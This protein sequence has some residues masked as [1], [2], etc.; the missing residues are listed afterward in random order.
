MDWQKERSSITL[1]RQTAQATEEKYIG[2]VDF[3]RSGGPSQESWGIL[4]FKAE[5]ND[6]L[7]LL[8]LSPAPG[9]RVPHTQVH[10]RAHKNISRRE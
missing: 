1:P 6:L 5:E 4:L 7:V 3:T 8:Q 10:T 2:S 9:S